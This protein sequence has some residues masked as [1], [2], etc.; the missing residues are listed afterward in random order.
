MKKLDGVKSLVSVGL[1]CLVVL[2]VSGFFVYQ[3]RWIGP[4]FILIGVLH[5]LVLKCFRIEIKSV[6]PDIMFGMIDNGILVVGALIG[7]NFAGALGAIVGGSAMNVI[8]DGI[9]GIFEG[10]TAEYLRR[11]KIRETRIALSTALGKMAGCLF[12]AG[13]VLLILW[14]FFLF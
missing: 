8:T 6:W 4:I 3:K 10:W 1:L 7:A 5:L 12:G 9:A 2:A 14:S 13:F 11:H